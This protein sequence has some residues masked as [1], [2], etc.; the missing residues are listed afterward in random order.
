MCNLKDS[1]AGFDQQSSLLEKDAEQHKG[2]SSRVQKKNKPK[3]CINA[4][5]HLELLVQ[6]EH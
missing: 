4:I 2:T 3:S 1:M 6:R 5:F